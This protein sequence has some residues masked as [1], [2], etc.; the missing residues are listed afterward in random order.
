[1]MSR[2]LFYFIFFVVGKE[3]KMDISL[4]FSC[5]NSFFGFHDQDPDY[6]ESSRGRPRLD[7]SGPANSAPGTR[8]QGSALVFNWLCGF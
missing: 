6:S 8:Y 1:M 5:L 4:M 7:Y 2:L 3:T